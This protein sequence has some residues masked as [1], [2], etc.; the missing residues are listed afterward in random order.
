MSPPFALH[1]LRE[2][3][4]QR[5]PH[6]F[7]RSLRKG[8]N[9]SFLATIKLDAAKPLLQPFAHHDK[10]WRS[11]NPAAAHF[12]LVFLKRFFNN[13]HYQTGSVRSATKF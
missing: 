6:P 9:N 10:K 3:A 4:K 2:P 11:K 5:V 1:A 8:E 12:P 13:P 7:P